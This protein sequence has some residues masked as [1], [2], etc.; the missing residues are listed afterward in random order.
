M[1]TIDQ[2]NTTFANELAKYGHPSQTATRLALLQ[3]KR[4]LLE[5]FHI[6]PSCGQTF[7][8][9]DDMD[10]HVFQYHN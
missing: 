9:Y 5:Y 2:I 8:T 6:C 4:K 3:T 10:R 7:E 1:I